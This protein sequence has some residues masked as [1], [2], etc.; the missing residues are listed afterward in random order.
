MLKILA[1]L[2]V[3]L[4]LALAQSGT[5]TSGGQPIP[6]VTIRATMGERAVTTVTDENG[7]FA[8]QDMLPGTW[9]VEADM[10]GLDPVKKDVAIGTSPVKID[11]TLQL[12]TVRVAPARGPEGRGGGG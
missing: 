7:A 2:G 12:Q 11:L 6:G 1:V 3:S 10:C 8:F 5:V 4:T 9:A